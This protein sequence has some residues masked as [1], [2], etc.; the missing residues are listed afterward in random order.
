MFFVSNR[1][2][3]RH[4]RFEELRLAETL[5]CGEPVGLA[6]RVA[7]LRVGPVTSG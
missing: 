4:G 5:E 1:E 3:D 7:C 2:D 6:A